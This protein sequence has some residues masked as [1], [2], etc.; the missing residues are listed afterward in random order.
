MTASDEPKPALEHAS[1]LR[2]ANE[3][4]VIA[5]LHAQTKAESATRALDEVS[6]AA[7]LDTL[8]ALPN[9]TLMLDRFAHAIAS[10]KRHRTRLALL[11]LDLNG[12]KQINDA[13][14]HI[15]GDRVLKVAAEALTSSVREEDTVSRHGGDEF[16]ILVTQVAEASDAV[17]VAD[18]IIAALA[19]PAQVDDHVFHLTASI[20]ISIYPDDGE[21]IEALIGLA[22]AAMFRAKRSGQDSCVALSDGS[23]MSQEIPVPALPAKQPMPIID[24]TAEAENPCRNAQLREANEHLVLTALN[25]QELH[26]A[27]ERA[28]RRQTEFLA[29]AAHEL[30]NPLTPLLNVAALLSRV[31]PEDLPKM[32]VMIERQVAHMVRLVSDLVDVSRVNTG[33]L[34][35][36]RGYVDMR[37]V[38]D[39][40][41]E[42]IRPA[43]EKRQQ[44]LRI[45]VPEGTFPVDGDIVRLVQIFSN[46]LDNASK[47][48][49]IGGEITLSLITPD[50]DTIVVTVSD[51]GIGMTADMLP[52]VFE[53]F[54]Q[55]TRTTE[56]NGVGLGIGLTVVRELVVGHGGTVVATSQG[57]G[58][59]SQFVITLPWYRKF[60]A[61]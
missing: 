50:D 33:K 61:Q 39:V 52:H 1:H 14:G 58:Q 17:V 45:E 25:A 23:P 40:A 32:Q 53:A 11:F 29:M 56:F 22:D 20:G 54:V 26:A 2:E 7:E 3:R 19:A 51:N 59:G 57:V 46:L 34:R 18:K 38:I 10:A 42:T 36:E 37:S 60:P 24:P 47:Y 41:V 12:F 43:I 27:A 44:L 28:N 49:E 5:A 8:T 35:L 30:R 13:L 31:R 48:T 16:L 55:S 6:R 15:V 21:D 4:L 9:R